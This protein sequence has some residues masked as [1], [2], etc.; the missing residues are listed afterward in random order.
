[1]TVEAG[2]AV[3]AGLFLEINS[4]AIA[5]MPGSLCFMNSLGLPVWTHPLAWQKSIRGA[6]RPLKTRSERAILS[7]S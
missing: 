7:I 1:M 5:G 4:G 2:P 6:E 3:L